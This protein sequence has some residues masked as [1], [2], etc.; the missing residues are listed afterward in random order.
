MDKRGKKII[1][2]S[3][4]L[5]NQNLRFPG[6]GVESG[7]IR[8]L[9]I[10]LIKKGIGLEP[11]PCLERLGWGGVKRKTFY[12]YL[13]KISKQIGS[14]KFPIIKFFLR[15]WIR[16]FKKLCQ[17]EARKVV[18]QIQ[19]YHE[20]GYSII[21]IIMTNDSPTCGVTK[22]INLFGIL[23]KF[24]DLRII[25]ELTNPTFERMKDFIP[26]LCE[27]GTG[28]FTSE[29]INEIKKKKLNTKIIGF[30]I[31]NDLTEETE[32]VLEKLI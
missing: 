16:K 3:R 26:N 19:N 20:S 27:D 28:L 18:G 22:T 32:R 1:Y 23:S 24:K 11:L 6:I 17:K 5:L 12:K 9:T 4:C 29:L 2:L 8:E 7:A 21:G 31:W 15:I 14:F 25:D 30:D 13:P 10:S